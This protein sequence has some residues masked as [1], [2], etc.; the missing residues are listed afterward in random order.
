VIEQLQ[1]QVTGL[2]GDQAQ[3]EMLKNE[4]V[5]RCEE[6]IRDMSVRERKEKSKL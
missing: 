6:E 1:K 4:T 2:K 3:I 5:R